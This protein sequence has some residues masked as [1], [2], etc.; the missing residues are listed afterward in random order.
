MNIVRMPLPTQSPA[1]H[2]R[3]SI[4]VASFAILLQELH[5]RLGDRLFHLEMLIATYTIHSQVIGV[6]GESGRSLV[7]FCVDVGF[8][9]ANRWTTTFLK[10]VDH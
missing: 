10:R 5:Y 2:D 6:A 8:Q 9:V 1:S 3:D 7:Y 4:R